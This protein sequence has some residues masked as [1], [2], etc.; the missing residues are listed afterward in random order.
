[1]GCSPT[2]FACFDRLCPCCQA[3]E[4]FGAVHGQRLRAR[5]RLGPDD[6]GAPL[7]RTGLPHSQLPPLTALQLPGGGQQ[8]PP[9]AACCCV[10]P[11]P[12]G[13]TAWLSSLLAPILM[14]PFSPLLATSPPCLSRAPGAAVERLVAGG[15]CAERCPAFQL[16]EPCEPSC[17]HCR[18]LSGRSLYCSAALRCS[19]CVPAGP[20]GQPPGQP[21]SPLHA[22]FF[23]AAGHLGA[24]IR[25]ARGPGA[26][27]RS[28]PPG[29]QRQAV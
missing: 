17:F 18:R 20:H 14:T 23:I 1:M 21:V 19:P 27:A 3:L 4:I 9:A 10:R 12:V 16:G 8:Q 28:V 22:N 6:R 25:R 13:F 29:T 15:L 5:L 2:C 11:A 26:A 7:S 24:G